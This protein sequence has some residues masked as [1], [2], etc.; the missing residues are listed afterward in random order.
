MKQE[1]ATEAVARAPSSLSREVWRR[2]R[3]DLGTLAG[4][5]VLLLASIITLIAPILAPYELPVATD[6]IAF[7]MQGSYPHL[8][9]F[10]SEGADPRYRLGTDRNGRGMLSL[11]VYGIRGSMVTGMIAV[12]V[13]AVVGTSLGL[14]AGWLRGVWESGIMRAADLA[15]AVPSLIVFALVAAVLDNYAAALS[16]DA[17][18]GGLLL[19]A[20]IVSSV[21]WASVA[22]LVRG[23]VLALKN[24][25][26]V[27]AAQAIGV[28]TR[29]LLLRQVL[30]HTL[31]AVMVAA[32]S[33]LPVLI[34]AE[35]FLQTINIGVQ[36]ATPSLGQLIFQEFPTTVYAPAFVLMPTLPIVAVSLALSAVGDGIQKAIEPWQNG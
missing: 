22:R 28:P 34:I 29:R 3:R 2:L 15:E 5:S 1:L 36:P 32:S 13:V 31:G 23:Q 26:W 17:V 21:G 14:L 18:L 19:M 25:E 8:A 30:P 24:R 7:Q 27:L 6:S 16:L 9:P 12:A 10:W 33:Q 20:I 4:G 11:L 35:G